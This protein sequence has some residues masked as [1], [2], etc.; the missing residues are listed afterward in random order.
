MSGLGDNT[1][2][3]FYR[4]LRALWQQDFIELLSRIAPDLVSGKIPPSA[5]PTGTMIDR[6]LYTSAARYR[7]GDL[8]VDD[9]GFA[10]VAIQSSQG[11][12]VADTD[13]WRPL[14]GGSIPPPPDTYVYLVD[15][16]MAYLLDED[17]AYLWEPA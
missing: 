16:D 15:S 9:A 10:Y 17:G 7:K 5:L 3:E 14:A 11:V 1:L 8:V 13:Y 12:G 2:N 4:Q 6:G